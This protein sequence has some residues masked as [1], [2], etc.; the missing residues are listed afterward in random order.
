VEQESLNNLLRSEDLRIL[1]RIVDARINS[2]L[3]DGI[4]AAYES[5]ET[6]SYADKAADKVDSAKRYRHCLEVI[7]ELQA[8]DKHHEIK[9]ITSPKP[10]IKPTT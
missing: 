7:A 2:A 4:E 9:I 1:K 10:P 5:D 6:N 3:V 8:A